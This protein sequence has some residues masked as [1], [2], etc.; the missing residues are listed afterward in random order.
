MT[1]RLTYWDG[2][3]NAEI[4]RLMLIV[5]GEPWTEKVYGADEAHV[6]SFDHVKVMLDD[7]VLAFDQVRIFYP[8]YKYCCKTQRACL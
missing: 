1:A 4:I 5:T 7:G 3:G 8:P 6:Q 2:R